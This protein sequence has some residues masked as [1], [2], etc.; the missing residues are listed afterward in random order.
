MSF[1][2]VFF[3]IR[4][5]EVFDN[6]IGKNDIELINEYR[7]KGNRH[8][9]G[10]LCISTDIHSKENGVISKY[11]EAGYIDD[12]F[13]IF[14]ITKTPLFDENGNYIGNIGFALDKSDKYSAV[15]NE[16]KFLLKNNKA[17][18]LSNNDFNGSPFVYYIKE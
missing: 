7:N 18:Q 3:K 11:I 6:I 17:E 10:E 14:D 13:V 2:K 8:D 16:I 5:D 15:V 12:S 4:L 1:K 9:F